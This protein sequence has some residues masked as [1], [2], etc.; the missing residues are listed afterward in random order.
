MYKIGVCLSLNL[1][2]VII[3]KVKVK[4]NPRLKPETYN[5]LPIISDGTKF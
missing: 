3:F 4:Q 2:Q 5:S 1:V